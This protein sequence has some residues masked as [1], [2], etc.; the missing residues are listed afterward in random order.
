MISA[1]TTT[2]ALIIYLLDV[3]GSMAEPCG[4]TTKIEALNAAMKRH[5][6]KMVQRSTKGATISDRYHIA[7]FAY[8]NQPQD[9]LGGIKKISELVASGIPALSPMELTGTAEAFAEAEKLL[10]SVIGNYQ[11]CPQPLVC[12]MTDGLYNTSD[13][14]PI[15]KRILQMSV[16]DGNVLV[17]NI[18]LSDNALVTPITD[19][20]SWMGVT[21]TSELQDD[22][23]K[24]LFH[25]SSILPA[26][27]QVAMKGM[28]FSILPGAALLLPGNSPELLEL[29][30]AV[31]GMTGITPASDDIFEN[32]GLEIMA[33]EEAITDRAMLDAEAGL[34][35]KSKSRIQASKGDEQEANLIGV[36]NRNRVLVLL[37]A[38][39]K[40]L[41]QRRVAEAME[42]IEQLVATDTL[43]LDEAIDEIEKG[44][45]IFSK[46]LATAQEM[47][48]TL[49][50]LLAA[51]Q[52]FKMTIAHPKLLSKGS[53]SLF[54]VQ[55]NIQEMESKAKE[56]IKLIIGKDATE[57]I[58]DTVLEYGQVVR[59]ELYSPDIT[60]PEPKTK[61]INLSTNVT[62]FL[63]KPMDNCF[64]GEHSVE[65]SVIENDTNVEL[66]SEVFKVMVVDFAFDH[67][68]RPLLSRVLASVLGIGSLVM[69]ILTLLEQIDKTFGLTSGTAAGV[70]AIVVY[71]NFY[72]LY[73][74]IKPNK[75]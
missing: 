28:E 34:H 8:S 68:S 37:D 11:D 64:P 47:E 72:D 29:G 45:P 66:Q 41:D 56:K 13:P 12:H 71:A 35:P 38:L 20:K 63:A 17:E 75:P 43:G 70:L 14:Y 60:F 18:F 27:Y 25:M 42:I 67:V 19:V 69:Y 2:P 21:D 58:Y 10:Q 51:Y 39:G 62:T 74:R 6:I 4:G 3:S 46:S 54:M 26:E 40:M 50:D 55:L 23:S 44:R 57:H 7:M 15:A 16:N 30:L 32:D 22:Y 1:T 33:P 48:N 53:E 5:V 31:S 36:E 65:L 59:I 9:V 49:A 52:K 61:R 73:Q 24:K